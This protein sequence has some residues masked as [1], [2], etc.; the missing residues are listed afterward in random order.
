MKYVAASVVT[1]RLIDTQNDYRTPCACAKGYLFK[2]CYL[3]TS[4]QHSSC[5]Y[6]LFP[7]T[8][9]WYAC[10]DLCQ[11]VRNVFPLFSKECQII[12]GTNSL[13]KYGT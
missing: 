13:K 6:I 12:R 4:I 7:L 9:Q 8:A 3:E 1:D 2:V 11:K 10:D 5:M